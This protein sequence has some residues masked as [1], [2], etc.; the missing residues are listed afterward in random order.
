M[1]RIAVIGAG[2]MGLAAAYEAL[3]AGHQ[4]TVYEAAPEA[5]GMAAHF[6][7]GDISTERFYHFICKTDFP[8]F[9]LL[10]ELGLAGKLHWVATSMG[11]L[12]DRRLHRWGDPLALLRFPRLSLVQ[13]IRYALLVFI[14]TR[15]NRW[16]SLEHRNAREWITSWCGTAVYNLMWRKLFEQKFYEHADNVSAAWIWTRIRRIGRSRRSLLQEELG[17]IEGGSETLVRALAEAIAA[18]GGALRL[19]TPVAQVV[20]EH[21]RVTGVLAG[22]ERVPADSVICTVPTPLIPRL[23]PDLGEPA[24]QAYKEIV[25]IGVVCAVLRL[26]RSVTPH[27][28]VNINEPD[29]EI[30]GIIE[31]SNLRRVADHVV[32]VPYYM[33]ATHPKWGWTDA[34][35]IADALACL[36]RVNPQLTPG[37]LITAHVARLRHA[38]PICPPGFAAT[39]P[40]VQTAIAGLQIADT[41]FY[42]PED[43]GL[44]ESIRLGRAMAKSV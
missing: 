30:P 15:R 22:G 19:G 43:R 38:Q 10:K 11:Y 32:Y 12:I 4:V 42:Y 17:Y 7:L 20:T 37:D 3:L 9:E 35:F 13:K 16:D 28:W 23:V 6:M 41:C 26:K 31:F 21:G 18:R 27:F 44:A 36:M 34:E 14:S 39:L 5:G 24:L 33:P 40:A 29:I 8:T 1:A 2:I 25:N